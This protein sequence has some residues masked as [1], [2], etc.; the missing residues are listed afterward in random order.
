VLLRGGGSEGRMRT[1][2]GEGEF[3]TEGQ[4]TPALVFE[5]RRGD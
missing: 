3:Q 2:V 4:L 5:S 1:E